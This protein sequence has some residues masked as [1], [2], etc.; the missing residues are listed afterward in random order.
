MKNTQPSRLIELLIRVRDS[1]LVWDVMG[2]IYN[3][4]IYDAI[5][6]LYDHIARELDTP[7]QMRI[8]DAG[9][10]RGYISLL[11][12]L[13]NPEARI[14]GIDY[15]PMQVREAENFRLQKTISNCSFQQGN[16]M[17]IPFNDETF[18]AA[19]SIG[20]I[21]HWPDA[22]R[23]LAEIRR[24]LKPGGE[25]IISET[26]QEASD[27]AIRQFIRRFQIWFIP[28]RLLFWGLRRV[29]FGQSF[30]ETT[31]AAAVREAGFL[32]VECQ[33]VPTCPYVIV[34]A[35]K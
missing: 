6:E 13:G 27:E 19:V 1:R 29:I 4:P 14:T 23:G 26:D 22:L 28:D 21:K 8:L 9:S 7:G 10:G 35:R 3:R 17:D 34:K 15:S 16:T 18:D 30:S 5:A 2:S 31:L 12:A 24:V 20:S 33:R 25:V 11:L 32:N